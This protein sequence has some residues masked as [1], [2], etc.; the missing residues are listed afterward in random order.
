LNFINKLHTVSYT[1]KADKNKRRCDGL[2]AQDVQQALSE[3]GIDFSGLVVDSDSAKTLNLSYSEFVLPLIN[4]VQE[5]SR[6]NEELKK[7]IMEIKSMLKQK[8]LEL[9]K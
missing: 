3:L 4:S 5:L 7:E 8:S 9:N 6:Q 1:Y 2:I